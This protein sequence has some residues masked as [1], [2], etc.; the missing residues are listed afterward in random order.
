M[1]KSDGEKLRKLAE[2]GNKG[3]RP[4]LNVFLG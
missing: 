2:I 1:K 3:G 4:P